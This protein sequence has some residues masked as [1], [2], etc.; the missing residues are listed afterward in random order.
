MKL[1][2]REDKN[3]STIRTNIRQMTRILFSE[4]FK[5]ITKRYLIRLGIFEFGF[6]MCQ[7]NLIRLTVSSHVHYFLF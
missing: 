7:I 3:G 1:E 5:Q 2:N 4:D 6:P